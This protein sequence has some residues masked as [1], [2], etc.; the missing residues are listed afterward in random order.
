[1]QFED[2]ETQSSWPRGPLLW[3]GAAI[4]ALHV[5]FN[6]TISLSTLVQNALHFATFSSLAV[7][8]FPAFAKPFR[9]PT[10]WRS[11][12]DLSIGAVIASSAL[13][14]VLAEDSIYERGVRL[15]P[16]DWAASVI[17]IAGA[18]EL[19]RRTT[20]WLI[21]A[22]IVLAL[23]Y[24]GWWGE[25]VPGVFRFPGLSWETIVFRSIFSDEGLF[26]TIARI[27]SSFVFMFILFGAFLLR[28]GAGDFVIAL[29]QVVAGRF[30]GGPGYVSVIASGLTGTISGSAIANTASTGVITIPMMK[31]AG[32]RP[33]FAGGLEAAASTG[34][35]IM[36]PIMGAGAFIM[37]SYTQIPY[38]T[39][40]LVSLLP[41]LLYYA[42]LGFYVRIE[43]RKLNMQVAAEDHASFF[44]LLRQG[45]VSFLV[46]I[47]LLMG[48]LVAGFTPTTAALI[49]IPGVVIATWMTPRPMGPRAILEALA[50]GSRNMASTA[51]LLCTVGLI[52]N[53]I[54]MAGIGNTFSLMINTWSGDSLLIALA[55]VAIAS[56]ILGMGLPVTA[57]YVILGTLSAPALYML[58]S[59]Q[60]MVSVL[61]QGALSPETQAILMLAGDGQPLPT[62]PMDAASARSLLTELPA[63]LR[64]LLRE[65]ILDAQTL[66]LAL[67]SAHMI[68]FWL[69]QDSNVTPP[70]CLTAFT[71]A[72]IAKAPPMATGVEAWKI[73]KGLY[74]VPILFAFTPLLSTSLTE[75]FPIF[76]F[77]L[78]GLYAFSAAI[79]GWM[80]NRIGLA[81]R[82]ALGIC[83]VLLIFPAGLP[84]K[85]VAASVVIGTLIANV[86]GLSTATVFGGRR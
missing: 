24:A 43:A 74:I 26:G 35:Q 48:L 34:G 58:I 36:P 44:H 8:L 81:E 27:S 33:K 86:A 25:L 32:F 14:I 11:I 54:A 60:M 22:L 69:S 40:V 10:N 37:A 70:V 31:R 76:L 80:E 18:L 17:L 28:S 59:D 68:V 23:T 30:I 52:I 21:P 64:G 53:V 5:W 82:L 46:P 29:S 50:L 15:S 83:V 19:T 65:N 4:A 61:M 51:I 62:G 20:G 79:Q 16:V 7:V 67:L 55:L 71:A 3:A 13:Y 9:A 2:E 72:A 56:L 42:T 85:L 1:M 57:A 73:A 78:I 49:A 45:G 63:E 39:I 47:I 41:A 6:L 38:T 84:L 12:A 75:A 77:A 66:A